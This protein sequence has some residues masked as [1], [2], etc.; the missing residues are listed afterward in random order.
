MK[1]AVFLLVGSV[2]IINFASNARLVLSQDRI[3]QP[4]SEALDGSFVE[5]GRIEDNSVSLPSP[6]FTLDDADRYDYQGDLTQN[7]LEDPVT[8]KLPERVDEGT[9][10]VEASST[11]TIDNEAVNTDFEE[12]RDTPPIETSESDPNNTPKNTEPTNTDPPISEPDPLCYLAASP[13]CTRICLSPA[14]QT[15]DVVSACVTAENEEGEFYNS[16]IEG[17]DTPIPVG[18]V[19]CYNFKD[20]LTVL[21]QCGGRQLD[22]ILS[23]F[24]SYLRVSARVQPAKG[25][26]CYACLFQE[27]PTCKDQKDEKSCKAHVIQ[28]GLKA[29][30]EK[31]EI[32]NEC[33]WVNEKC[34]SKWQNN[35]AK[36]CSRYDYCLL[37]DRAGWKDEKMVRD[38]LAKRECA[39]IAET[40]VE[41]HG[42]GCD[43]AANDAQ[44]CIVAFPGAETCVDYTGCSTFENIGSALAKF[45][46][47]K[48]YAVEKQCKG[49]VVLTGYQLMSTDPHTC[50]SRITFTID[51][52]DPNSVA[53][54]LRPCSNKKVEGTTPPDNNCVDDDARKFVY[55]TEDG[56]KPSC[57]K[58]S[59]PPGASGVNCVYTTQNVSLDDCD[60]FHGTKIDRNTCRFPLPTKVAK[61]DCS[62]K[63]KCGVSLQGR[64]GI[65]ERAADK[66]AVYADDKSAAEK[67]YAKNAGCDQICEKAAKDGRGSQ[68]TIDGIFATAADISCVEAK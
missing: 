64:D 12:A 57:K 1:K 43:R 41:G 31:I 61:F 44:L 10:A 48:K 5:P 2:L 56:T 27:R 51:S 55:C 33:R 9:V 14:G 39:S 63:C 4:I 40:T 62:G 38:H 54:Q 42:E 67:K 23:G 35:C 46:K 65:V 32:K 52:S 60:K 11:I 59:C 24:D 22:T 29:G 7:V 13:D 18:L 28:G 30:G 66:L 50:E 47:V 16:A 45:D 6:D 3:E 25:K 20:A 19:S 58:C 53:C 15:E 8:F 26:S 34:I 49:K 17:D 68:L 37:G 36:L 21:P